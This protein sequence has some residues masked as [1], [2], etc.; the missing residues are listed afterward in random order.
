V[1]VNISNSSIM[2]NNNESVNT[3]NDRIR[4][5]VAMI[6]GI[7]DNEIEEILRNFNNE[8]VGV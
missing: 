5:A 4:N 3:L 2:S 7:G 1:N 8:S 6:G